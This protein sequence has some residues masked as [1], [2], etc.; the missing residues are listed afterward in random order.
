M[1]GEGRGGEG[2]RE[3]SV[4]PEKSH[5]GRNDGCLHGNMCELMVKLGNLG[6]VK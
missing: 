2:R 5:V 4:R 3:R 1:G 6:Q